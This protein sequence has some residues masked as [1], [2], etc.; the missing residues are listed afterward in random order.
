M[1][2]FLLLLVVVMSCSAPPPPPS[3]SPALAPIPSATMTVRAHVAAPPCTIAMVDIRVRDISETGPYEALGT[4]DLTTTKPIDNEPFSLN[5]RIKVRACIQGGE[6]VGILTTESGTGTE[7]VVLRKRKPPNA[8]AP[9]ID[10][11]P[12][13]S[14]SRPA[15]IR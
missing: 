12:S 1:R 2:S 7:Y 10:Y 9:T 13:G 3:S 11:F 15:D 5:D 4:I 8:A 6:A 14:T